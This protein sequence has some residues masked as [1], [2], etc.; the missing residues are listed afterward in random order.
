MKTSFRDCM[1]IDHIAKRFQLFPCLLKLTH[2]FYRIDG[3]VHKVCE[4]QGK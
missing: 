3:H 4:V 2:A 1:S